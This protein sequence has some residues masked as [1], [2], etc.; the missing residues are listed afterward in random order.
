MAEVSAK[1]LRFPVESYVPDGIVFGKRAEHQG[2]FW[3]VHLGED[4]NLP[5]GTDVYAIGDGTVV[6]AA[7]HEGTAEKGNWGHI[8][9][10]RHRHPR[11]KKVFYSLY[12]HLG[13]CFKNIGDAVV[14][15]EPIGFVGEAYVPENG[16]WPAHLHFAIYI[17]PWKGEVLPGYWKEGDKRTR[18]EWWRCPSEFIREYDGSEKKKA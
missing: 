10:I 9:I 18:P 17:G 16:F 2:I 13:K 3:G 7:L 1:R 14:C 11:L 5:A 12:A 15:G 8:I 4:C 6:Y